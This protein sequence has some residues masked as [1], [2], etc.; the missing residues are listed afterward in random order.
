MSSLASIY[1]EIADFL[2]SRPTLEQITEF[3]LSDTSDQFISHL[4][5][6]NRTTGLTPDQDEILD[7]YTIIEHLMQ[8]VKVAAFAKLD[9][10][11]KSHE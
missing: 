8:F 5:E 2:V 10:K 4:L 9:K 6:L 11:G 3:H 7:D 1:T